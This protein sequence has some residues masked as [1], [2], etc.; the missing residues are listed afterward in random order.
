M[1]CFEVIASGFYGGN[2]LTDDRVIWVKSDNI[3]EVKDII[4]GTKARMGDE[5]PDGLTVEDGIDFILPGD[6]EK[7]KSKLIQFDQA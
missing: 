4:D 5:L 1:K 6:A 7:L 2:D 3:D